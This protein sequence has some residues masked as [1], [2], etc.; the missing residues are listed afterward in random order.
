MPEVEVAHALR[1]RPSLPGRTVPAVHKDGTIFNMHL[2]VRE[3][4]DDQG[5]RMFV[6]KCSLEGGEVVAVDRRAIVTMSRTGEITSINDGFTR[7]YGFSQSEAVGQNISIIMPAAIAAQ[8]DSFL[9]RYAK[10]GRMHVVQPATQHDGF[11]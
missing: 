2:E 5:A 8:H 7:L 6:G 11:A 1:R 3:I 9:E 4:R 10:R